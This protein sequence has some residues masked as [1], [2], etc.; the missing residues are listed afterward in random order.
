MRH[1]VLHI[2]YYH[3]YVLFLQDMYTKA[4]MYCPFNENDVT[5]NKDFAIIL[6]NRSAAL[7]AGNCNEGVIKDIDLA[8]K[9]GYPRELYFKVQMH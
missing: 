1:H 4:L 7:E 8:I 3:L 6:A 9:Y 5:K 2:C